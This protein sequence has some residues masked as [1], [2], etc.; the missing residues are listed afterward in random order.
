VGGRGRM[1]RRETAVRSTREREGK[2]GQDEWQ[3]LSGRKGKGP[4]LLI[5]KN[6]SQVSL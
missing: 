3:G 5:I 6:G 2:K 4:I 1:V